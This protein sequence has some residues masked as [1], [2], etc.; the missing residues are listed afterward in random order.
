MMQDVKK[1]KH[2][3]TCKYGDSVGKLLQDF[4]GEGAVQAE[5]S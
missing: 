4:R 5:S 1:N 3:M 2:T